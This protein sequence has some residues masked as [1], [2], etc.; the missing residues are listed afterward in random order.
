MGRSGRWRLNQVSGRMLDWFRRLDQRRF[1][2]LGPLLWISSKG[3]S[4]WMWP[5]E[6]QPPVELKWI[7]K[8]TLDGAP[9]IAMSGGF[10]RLVGMH[11][12]NLFEQRYEM[13]GQPVGTA[14][15]IPQQAAEVSPVQSWIDIVLVCALIFSVG[16]TFYRRVLQQKDAV[17]IDPPTPAPFQLRVYAGLVDLLP[18]LVTLAVLGI[19]K[20][21]QPPGRWNESR[22][23]VALCL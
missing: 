5:V 4:G 20:E 13:T 11:G 23:L 15:P 22:A 3:N 10:V 19:I 12:G 14:A 8:N 9:A 1:G 17:A 2:I 6:G 7:D 16:A 21:K 18:V